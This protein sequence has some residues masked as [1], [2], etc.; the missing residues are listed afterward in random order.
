ML[1]NYPCLIAAALPL[2]MAKPLERNTR[3]GDACMHVPS[4][5]LSHLCCIAEQQLLLLL[6]RTADGQAAGAQHALR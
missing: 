6:C 5:V 1:P 4:G 3:Y 2:Q